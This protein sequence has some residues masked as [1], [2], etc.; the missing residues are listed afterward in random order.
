VKL[1]SKHKPAAVAM[2]TYSPCYQPWF[3]VEIFQLVI[4]QRQY[5]KTAVKVRSKKSEF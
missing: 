4:Q 3:S 5:A 2:G 1:L